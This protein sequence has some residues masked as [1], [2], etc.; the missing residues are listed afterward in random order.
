[1]DD[2]KRIAATGYDAI[3]DD[4]LGAPMLFAGDD[5]ETNLRRVRESGFEVL[6]AELV[7][8]IEFGRE[9]AFPWV[10]ARRTGS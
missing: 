10:L 7:P 1:V 3:A 9:I 8:R 6:R 4:W 5:A 2:S